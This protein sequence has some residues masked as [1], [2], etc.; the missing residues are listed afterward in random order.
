[1]EGSDFRGDGLNCFGGR[2]SISCGC[3]FLLPGDNARRAL[4]W[5]PYTPKT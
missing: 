5:E 4:I 2:D 1:M 3:S